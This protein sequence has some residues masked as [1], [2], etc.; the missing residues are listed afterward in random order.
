[1]PRRPR[2]DAAVR[3]HAEAMVEMWLREDGLDAARADPGLRPVLANPKLARRSRGSRPTAHAAFAPWLEQRARRAHACSPRRPPG[4]R[5]G[6]TEWLGQVGKIDGRGTGARAVEARHGPD[7]RR[8]DGFAVAVPLLDESHL[9]V[10]ATPKRR[11]AAEAL[12]EN[13]LHAGGELLP[14]GPGAAAR[15]GH[16]QFTGALP[17]LYPLTRTGLLTVHDPGGCRS[18]W[19]SCPT[20]SAGCTPG[21]WSTATRRC[22]ALARQGAR[23][24]SRGWWRC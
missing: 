15:L 3:A 23:A 21:C 9:Q 5:A 2:A 24:P 7:R 20:G 4:P 18:C 11:D 22:A 13:L 17:G 1:M 10:V 16:R 14:A 12:V 6:S 8:A 19:R